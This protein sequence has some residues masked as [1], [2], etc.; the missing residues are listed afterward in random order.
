M[1]LAEILGQNGKTTEI[2]VE[3]DG[4]VFLIK[5]NGKDVD[6]EVLPFEVIGKIEDKGKVVLNPIITDGIT[7]YGEL[8]FVDGMIVVKVRSYYDD[9][10]IKEVSHKI[11]NPTPQSIY[12][13]YG[14]IMYTHQTI[15]KAF[16]KVRKLWQI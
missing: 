7:T 15:V 11:I 2:H 16:S 10:L 14:F 3:K 9:T 5:E 13:A 12:E 1:L 6:K 4:F 8:M